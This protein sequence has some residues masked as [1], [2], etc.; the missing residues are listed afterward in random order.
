MAMLLCTIDLNFIVCVLKKR[1]KDIVT[2]VFLIILLRA[3]NTKYVRQMISSITVIS[4]CN[5][6]SI[7]GI[8]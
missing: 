1:N 4:F 2:K 6:K 8:F 7:Y 3:F 5:L